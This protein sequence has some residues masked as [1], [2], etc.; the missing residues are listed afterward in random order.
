MFPSIAQLFFDFSYAALILIFLPLT[1]I[2]VLH[3]FSEK[4][5]TGGLEIFAYGS[6]IGTVVYAIF[7]LII[8]NLESHHQAASISI[9]LFLNVV[10]IAYWVKADVLAWLGRSDVKRIS[11]VWLS[12][13][14]LS[15]FSIAVSHL[16]ITFPDKLFDGPYVIKN[17]NLHVKIQTITGH[18]PADNYLPHL[19]SEFF[20]RD[21][22]FT[23]ERPLMPGQEVSNRPILMALIA[24]PFRAALDPPVRQ[25]GPLPK[26]KYL[27]TSWPDVGSLGED[28]YFSQ[29]L[30]VGVVLNAMV[31]IGA[32]L[33]FKSMGIRRKYALLGLLLIVF[34]PYYISQVLFTWP[35]ALAAFYLLLAV[36]AIGY[37]NW[38][39]VAGIL[40]ALAYLSHP[41]A[42]VFAASYGLYLFIQSLRDGFVGRALLH[43]PAARYTAMFFIMV[44]PW[45]IWTRL[46]LKIPSN[47]VSQNFSK[48]I[49]LGEM[50]WIRFHNL[51]E[52][53][54]PRIFDIYPFNADQVMQ[55]FLVCV[56][57]I[58][59][60]MFTVQAYYA[61]VKYFSEH[62]FIVLYGI[63]IPGLLII[64]VFSVPA[65][66]ALHGLQAIGPL[67]IA[68]S[69][70]WMQNN[71]RYMIL[72][73][74][75]A[76]QLFINFALLGARGDTLGL[77]SSEKVVEGGGYNRYGN[78][79]HPKGDKR[80]SLLSWRAVDI[81][82][83]EVEPNID[84][85]IVIN[86]VE[87]ASIWTN[88]PISLFFHDLAL[89]SS[90]SFHTALAIHPAVWNEAGSD[91]AVFRVEVVL[92]G[93]KEVLLERMINPY[94]NSSERSWNQVRVDLKRFENKQVDIIL[95]VEA[96]KASNDYADWAIWGSPY[97]Y[98]NLASQEA[99]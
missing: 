89:G 1:G 2:A 41:Y 43:S 91:G 59:G 64:G 23:D 65:V 12:W 10:S 53:V 35:K 50:V 97:V 74:L 45:F 13:L 56:P 42:I 84:V 93:N 47:L 48:D 36:H 82:N 79:D 90:P 75:F 73:L 69:L 68:L 21:I 29:F 51:Y 5:I 30:V 7:G 76:A 81:V 24:I 20:L 34:S 6:A 19:V 3:W 58:I 54:F 37:K 71:A 94:V 9:M 80:I 25:E 86:G 61:C 95:S 67:L 27:G 44:L 49:T 55:N 92:D 66:P 46:I 31:L 78:V 60:I 17:H 85:P 96:G 38:S 28:R 88:P 32:A 72:V 70:K 14:L 4:E 98:F 40:A 83:A 8:G 16:T 52:T 11:A 18:L 87:K 39:A 63:L 15:V 77:F 62:R 26:F 99:K 57:G 22:S 33:L